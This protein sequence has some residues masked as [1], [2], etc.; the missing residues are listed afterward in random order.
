[1]N[2]KKPHPVLIIPLIALI[3]YILSEALNFISQ[4]NDTEVVLGIS[5]ITALIYSLIFIYNKLT[6]NEKSN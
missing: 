2:F 5:I 3:S 1:M 4:P 6:K